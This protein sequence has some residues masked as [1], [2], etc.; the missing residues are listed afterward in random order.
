MC[1]WRVAKWKGQVI[2]WRKCRSKVI[3]KPM[4]D[5]KM[6]VSGHLVSLLPSR[7]EKDLGVML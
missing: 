3:T 4:V 2:G 6:H 7:A 1:E 5:A